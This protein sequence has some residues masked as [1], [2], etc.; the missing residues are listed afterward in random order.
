VSWTVCSSIRKLEAAA[1][2][3][4]YGGALAVKTLQSLP[5]SNV[6]RSREIRE[7]EGKSAL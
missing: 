1:N 7:L 3:A 5:G 4:Q 2:F 6:A